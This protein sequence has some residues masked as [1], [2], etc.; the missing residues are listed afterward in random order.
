[1]CSNA[2]HPGFFSRRSGS[3]GSFSASDSSASSSFALRLS[4]AC[5][6]FA[7]AVKGSFGDH[8]LFD[9][10][11]Y[12]GVGDCCFD[13]VEL[14]GV[15]PNSDGGHSK[16]F[17]CEAFLKHHCLLVMTFSASRFSCSFLSSCVASVF[18]F[19]AF[20]GAAGAFF[21]ASFWCCAMPSLM[22]WTFFAGSL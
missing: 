17:S 5:S 4:R 6:Y 8:A 14:V 1:M 10:S 3:V 22:D 18:C 9:E 16:Y 11:A 20:S 19:G 21:F 12:V 15:D 13:V 7:S 2:G